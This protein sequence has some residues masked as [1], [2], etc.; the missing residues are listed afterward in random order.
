[1]GKKS[2][3]KKKDCYQMREENFKGKGFL[4]AGENGLA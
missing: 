4:A 2:L 3:Q 1:M